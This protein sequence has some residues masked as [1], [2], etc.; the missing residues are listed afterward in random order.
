MISIRHKIL[1]I[2]VVLS[3]S[4]SGYEIYRVKSIN[5]R[6]TINIS[7]NEISSTKDW[8][9]TI[10]DYLNKRNDLIND[11]LAGKYHDNRKWTAQLKLIECQPLLN[12]DIALID[13]MSKNPGQ[14]TNKMS[15]IQVEYSNIR[16]LTKY[17]VVMDAKIS[18][19]ENDSKICYD[20]EIVFKNLEDSWLMSKFSFAE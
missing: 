17:E 19:M 5:S 3:L 4:Y 6:E 8:H 14:F 9:N 13:Y 1:L 15:S 2:L 16:Q 11:V 7:S 12:G 10:L 18:F 20:Y